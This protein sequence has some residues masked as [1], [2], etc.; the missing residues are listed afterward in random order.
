MPRTLPASRSGV[1]PDSLPSTSGVPRSPSPLESQPGQPSA[2][3]GRLP[4]KL[5]DS[6]HDCPGPRLQHVSCGQQTVPQWPVVSGAL[7]YMCEYQRGNIPDLSSETQALSRL[8]GGSEISRC[9]AGGA[10][11]IAAPP[12]HTLDTVPE[13]PKL[14]LPVNPT[15]PNR[16]T[17]GRLPAFKGVM[18]RKERNA[19]LGVQ[20]TGSV[21]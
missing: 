2:R 8:P 15:F 4:Q 14:P 5:G 9:G 19:K 17:V 21:T 10:S 18:E 1:Q 7:G 13:G 16:H 12:G 20:Q 6:G 11:S 3:S